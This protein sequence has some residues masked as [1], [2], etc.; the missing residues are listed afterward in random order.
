MI[1]YFEQYIIQRG[2][3]K[4]DR[5]CFSFLHLY[6]LLKLF[7]VTMMVL[8]QK[9]VPFT[10]AFVTW[11]NLVDP[12]M[13]NDGGRSM[14]GTIWKAILIL[15]HSHHINQT[16]EVCLTCHNACLFWPEFQIGQEV[17]YCH[18]SHHR[19]RTMT[20]TRFDSICISFSQTVKAARVMSL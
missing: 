7:L 18:K 13:T 9:R 2:Y 15:S 14:V 17:T 5:C 3:S 10:S 8:K 20:P 19:L 16:L 4:I 12:I 6:L 1:F 11:A